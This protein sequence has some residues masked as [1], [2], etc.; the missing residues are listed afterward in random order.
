VNGSVYFAGDTDTPPG[1]TANAVANDLNIAWNQ[2]MGMGDTFPV[3]S[4]AGQ[5][6][7]PG[8]VGKIIVPGVYEEGAALLL[9]AGFVATFDGQNLPNP[10]FI[11]KVG[12]DFS[13]V[14]TILLPSQ[15][16]LINGAVAKNIW[17]V[18]QRD[19]TIGSGTIWNGNILA[20]RTVTINNGSTV[21][22]RVLAGA[23]L[24]ATSAVT[25]TGTPAALGPTTTISVP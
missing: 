21:N 9:S 3:G 5:L 12:S 24:I 13:D 6:G 18:V 8:P 17:F 19:V 23:S 25:L 11:I 14:G 16:K 1:G 4:L 7:G 15:I 22:G 20:G 10:V 2:G